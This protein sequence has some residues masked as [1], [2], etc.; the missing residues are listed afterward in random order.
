M[1]ALPPE[2]DMLIVGIDVCYVPEADVSA[3]ARAVTERSAPQSKNTGPRWRS[4]VAAAYTPFPDCSRGK[5]LFS[6]KSR[7]FSLTL[8]G[9]P[10][11][12]LLAVGLRDLPHEL[13]PGHVNGAV[14]GPSLRPRIILEDLH[15]QRGVVG[16]DYT[17]L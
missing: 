16:K 8:L 15:H 3:C 7:M 5:S 1:S 2:A 12:R 9:R 13:G 4:I 10:A 14:D 11:H 6:R 17:G